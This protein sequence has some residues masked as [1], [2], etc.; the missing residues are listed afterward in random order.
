MQFHSKTITSY[1]YFRSKVAVIAIGSA[2]F[3]SS[4]H[5]FT[6]ISQNFEVGTTV[7]YTGTSF[8]NSTTSNESYYNINTSV[9]APN[10][11][12]NS[13][14]GN[15][16]R[17][18]TGQDMD[19]GGG[20]AFSST[21]P[22]FL[23]F[24]IS[25][26][27]GFSNYML[28]VDLAGGLTPENTNFVRAF[29]D[30]DGN[31]TYETAIFNF[32]GTTNSPYVNSLNNTQQLSKTF[33][34]FSYNLAAPTGVNTDLR[35]RFEFFNDSATILAGTNGTDEVFAFDNLLVTAIPEPATSLTFVS[36]LFLGLVRRRR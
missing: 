24:T 1:T 4:L 23:N 13:F 6:L 9:V 15:S 28:T 36:A 21:A 18:L 8:V 7:N 25:N 5:A 22:A 26:A 27:A 34:T 19:A 35:V 2:G 16:T 32:A 3:A 11:V 12:N 29:T 17:Y 20:V 30:N 10:V 14:V 31:G 33:S